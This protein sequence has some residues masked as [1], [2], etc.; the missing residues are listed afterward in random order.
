MGFLNFDYY[1]SNKQLLTILYIKIQMAS[2]KNL[3]QPAS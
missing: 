3:K 2:T 1:F